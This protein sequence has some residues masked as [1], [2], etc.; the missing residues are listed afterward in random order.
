MLRRVYEVLIRA[1]QNNI[2]PDAELGDERI[3]C[4]DLH[5]RP[6][7]CVSKACRGDMVITVWLD[8]CERGEALHDLLAR[9]GTREALQQF[10]QDQSG[11]DDD[12]RTGE[13]LSE[14][15]HLG[16]FNLD[17]ASER[18]RPDARID[19]ERHL[20]ERSAL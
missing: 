5:P 9:P 18:Q 13:R 19:Q 15:P 3:D 6:A 14:C 17:I 12:V 2:V 7:A 16:F 8:Q 1:Q 20:R 11:G 10:L 4:A